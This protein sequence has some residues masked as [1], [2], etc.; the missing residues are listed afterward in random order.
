MWVRIVG[1]PGVP[2]SLESL[3]R[4]AALLST[5]MRCPISLV[6][7]SADTHYRC[8]SSFPVL[9]AA[10]GGPAVPLSWDHCGVSVTL[11]SI[12]QA[13]NRGSSLPSLPFYHLGHRRSGELVPPSIVVTPWPGCCHSLLGLV[14]R[15]CQGIHQNTSKVLRLAVG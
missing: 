5:G 14:D 12:K 10:F 3:S 6:A 11:A 4:G 15:R 1:L 7:S 8:T 2:R 13:V 9:T